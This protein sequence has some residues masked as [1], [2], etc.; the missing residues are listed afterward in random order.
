MLL[1]PPA[2]RN[3]PSISKMCRPRVESHWWKFLKINLL[4][5]PCPPPAPSSPKFR[6]GSRTFEKNCTRNPPPTANSEASSP[7]HKLRVQSF[8]NSNC[9]WREHS[10]QWRSRS[11]ITWARQKKCCNMIGSRFTANKPQ[12]FQFC[13][14]VHKYRFNLLTCWWFTCL[15]YC[16]SIVCKPVIRII[17]RIRIGIKAFSLPPAVGN[18]THL[19]T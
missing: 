17:N 19:N 15:F 11:E 18:K 10:H 13:I 9:Q 4:L 2:R 16:C 8:R 5:Q 7:G 14:T 1:P 12:N 6:Q 3:V